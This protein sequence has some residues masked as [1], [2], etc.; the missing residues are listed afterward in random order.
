MGNKISDYVKANR[1]ASRELEF[2]LLGDGFHSKDKTHKNK[3]KYNRKDKHK[4]KSECNNH[5]DF[6]F[7]FYFAKYIKIILR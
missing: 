1:K 3:R 5:S 6:F 4:G 2:E 7:A